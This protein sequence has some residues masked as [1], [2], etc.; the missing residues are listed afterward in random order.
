MATRMAVPT[1]SAAATHGTSRT[2]WTLGGAAGGRDGP[3][4][5][6]RSGASTAVLTAGPSI[7]DSGDPRET[8]GH[9]T[10]TAEGVA[11]APAPGV[12]ALFTGRTR[13]GH[14]RLTRR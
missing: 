8:T 1:T 9:R 13:P 7:V 3:A 5:S 12:T 6:G 11:Y 14:R 4:T 2:R 10:T